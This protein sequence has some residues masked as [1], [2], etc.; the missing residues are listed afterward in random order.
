WLDAVGDEKLHRLL[1]PLEAQL[2]VVSVMAVFGQ[3]TARGVGAKLDAVLLAKQC[4]KQVFETLLRVAR[5][6]GSA[7]VKRDDERWQVPLGVCYEVDLFLL[8]PDGL[9]A[10][11][12]LGGVFLVGLRPAL[13]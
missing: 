10:G 11:L 12:L 1:A 7:F 5:K 6:F 8:L 9:G 13:R 3:R 4:R 2:P